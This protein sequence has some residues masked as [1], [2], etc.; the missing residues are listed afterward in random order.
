VP[1]IASAP[2]RRR[3]LRSGL[4]LLLRR[5]AERIGEPVR[6]FVGRGPGADGPPTTL[7]D[8]IDVAAVD[9]EEGRLRRRQRAESREDVIAAE[10]GVLGEFVPADDLERVDA[11]ERG[12]QDW[13]LS[14]VPR[15]FRLLRHAGAGV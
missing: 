1:P 13:Q 5:V 12:S 11:G 2:A 15:V 8:V 6:E 9:L 7:E 10:G 14:P 4:S 3:P